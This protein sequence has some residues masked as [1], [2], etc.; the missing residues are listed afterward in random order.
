M[1]SDLTTQTGKR[2]KS[3]K[4]AT[5]TADEDDIFYNKLLEQLITHILSFLPTE[6]A[7]RTSLLSKRWKTRWSSLTKLSIHDHRDG[8]NSSTRNFVRFVNRALVLTRGLT[9]DNF[10]LF[11]SSMYDSSLLDIWFSNIFNRRVKNL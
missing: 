11:L 5:A 7:V 9:M 4:I 2:H 10:A 6:D 1:E 3:T 8:S